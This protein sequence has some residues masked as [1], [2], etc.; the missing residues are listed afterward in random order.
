VTSGASIRSLLLIVSASLAVA[1][2]GP[3]IRVYLVEN[4][5]AQQPLVARIDLRGTYQGEPVRVVDQGGTCG[6]NGRAFL[7]VLGTTLQ[8]Q[9]GSLALQVNRTSAGTW[10]LGGQ[11]DVAML[12][13]ASRVW[14]AA[15]SIHIDGSRDGGTLD[16]RLRPVLVQGPLG[17]AQPPAVTP[18]GAPNLYLHG[19]FECIP[20]P[21]STAS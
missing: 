7:V 14:Q 1:G 15:G 20:Q 16:M 9:D 3:A 21:G 18:E 2:C 6:P 5:P 19:S 13:T 4:Q 11:G 12:F 8:G 10:D 17:G